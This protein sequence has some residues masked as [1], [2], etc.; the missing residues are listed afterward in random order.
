[1]K[2]PFKS[3]FK[4][5]QGFGER[6]EYY[7]QFG[8]AGHEG[9]DLIPNGTSWDI[10]ALADG[11]VVLDDDIVGSV[12]A[13]PYGKIVTLWHPT[14][15]KATMYCHLAE[16]FVV[17]GQQVKKGERIG[18][19]GATGNVDGAHL[20]LNLFETDANGIRLNRKNG[21]LGGIDPLPFLQAD[22]AV[23]AP[24]IAQPSE[25]TQ[26]VR[27]IVIDCYRA[28]CG[29]EPSADELKARLDSGINTYDLIRDICKNDIRFKS[30]W[31]PSG[32]P[33][34]PNFQTARVLPLPPLPD[35]LTPK[36]TPKTST[37]PVGT[38]KLPLA[39]GRASSFG[40]PPALSL[41]SQFLEFLKK[42]LR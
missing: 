8:L 39:N 2:S 29:E 40:N 28:L 32:M 21:F 27:Q 9:I 25:P 15:N 18:T 41:F 22:D 16:N 26:P 38:W 1:M 36:T 11:V 4:V 7:K 31:Q 35:F 33:P 24:E 6:P 23:I 10:L 42:K 14:L 37:E 34:I 30:E 12:S 3:A 20:H 13:D 17:Y 19:M 5:T